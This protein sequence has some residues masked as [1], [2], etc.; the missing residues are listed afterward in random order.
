MRQSAFDRSLPVFLL[1]NALALCL[2]TSGAC[3]HPAEVEPPPA[4][5]PVRPAGCPSCGDVYAGTDGAHPAAICY[6]NPAP[7][8]RC[9][10]WSLLEACGR[11]ACWGPA[12]CGEGATFEAPRLANCTACIE[13]ACPAE[14]K[15]CGAAP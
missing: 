7:P 15:M 9:Q 6:Q 3:G 5:C 13:R 1:T 8:E 11:A 12:D 10:P 2:T 14:V 4:E